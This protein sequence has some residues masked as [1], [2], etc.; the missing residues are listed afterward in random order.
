MPHTTRAITALQ[1]FRAR[2][3]GAAGRWRFST[4]TM[5]AIA[6]EHVTVGT[7]QA[8]ASTLLGI[9]FTLDDSMA[10]GVLDLVPAH[11]E[12]YFPARPRR[13]TS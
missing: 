11:P 12:P 10:L 2:S 8:R 13:W 6:A 9:P 5:E 3:R 4:A 1:S 7:E